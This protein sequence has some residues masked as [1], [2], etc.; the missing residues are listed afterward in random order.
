LRSVRVRVSNRSPRAP[1]GRGR[2]VAGE[3]KE[4][5]I[6]PF[7]F[8]SNCALK[9]IRR[10]AK[11]VQAPA[12]LQVAAPQDGASSARSKLRQLSRRN[13]ALPSQVF[14]E[15]M[16]QQYPV[17][18]Y[19]GELGL[20][21][22]VAAMLPSDEAPKRAPRLE[23]VLAAQATKARLDELQRI[24]AEKRSLSLPEKNSSPNPSEASTVRFEEGILPSPRRPRGWCGCLPRSTNVRKQVTFDGQVSLPRSPADPVNDRSLVEQEEVVSESDV[25]LLLGA[26]REHGRQYN[27]GEILMTFGEIRELGILRSVDIPELILQAVRKLE[28]TVDRDDDADG[29]L[30]HRRLVPG[31]DDDVTVTVLQVESACPAGAKPWRLGSFVP[32]GAVAPLVDLDDGEL[33]YVLLQATT[34]DGSQKVSL[35]RGYDR[36][37]HHFHADVLEQAALALVSAGYTGI[38]C[39]GGGLIEHNAA[40]KWI[41]V[42]GSSHSFGRADHETTKRILINSFGDHTYACPYALRQYKTPATTSMWTAPAS[43]PPDVRPRLPDLSRPDVLSLAIARP[44]VA[45]RAASCNPVP[46]I[47]TSGST[48]I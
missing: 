28:A 32:K 2:E 24:A 30:G 22:H 16:D 7:C 14:H 18:A 15:D 41:R 42:G 48:T 46:G 17:N 38:S 45:R 47:L 39:A 27:Q 11:A 23:S 43:K 9:S 44:P 33:H 4:N 31:D 34:P 12:Q 13:Y 35:V 8:S 1:L 3:K 21:S 6:F 5:A 29:T 25:S 40:A 36:R 19:A 26:V 20:P 10:M 37:E